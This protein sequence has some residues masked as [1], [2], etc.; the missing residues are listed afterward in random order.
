[1]R[2]I[3]VG[4]IGAGD[5]ASI[6][7]VALL[8]IPAV[9]ITNVFDIDS[10]RSTQLASETGAKVCRSAKE[11]VESADVDVVYVLTPQRHHYEGAILALGAGK[12]TFI[13]K[14]VS[15]STTEIAEMIHLSEKNSCLCVPGHN[16]IHAHE[17][18]L[19][20]EMIDSG[21]LGE[22]RG[23]WIIFMVSLPPEIRNRIPGPLREVMIHQF[24]ST[25]FLV[26]RP[27][28]VFAVT[29]DFDSRG[30]H[31]EDQVTIVGKMPGGALVHLFAS[32][33]AEDLTCDPWTLKYKIIGSLGSASHTWS[34]SRLS[35]R[36]QP[37]WDL[38]AYWQ[39]FREEDRYFV[40]EC[41]RG[42]NQPLSSMTDASICLQMLQAAENS[43]ASGAVEPLP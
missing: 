26:G 43:L 39:T 42:G 33:V 6:H 31:N 16:Y 2:E 36:P 18:R 28:S 22:I 29:S 4:F 7:K 17:L 20:K 8:R 15:L 19:A 32:F 14:P 9:K 25:L 37:V 34:L 38:P 41:L 12:H 35:N 5:I 24:Y 30:P 21:K 1:M 13:E 3:R 40:E 23:L 10:A 27:E 11:L